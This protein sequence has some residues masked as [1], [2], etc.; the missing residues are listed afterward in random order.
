MT[1]RTFLR[2][3]MTKDFDALTEAELTSLHADVQDW[4]RQLA[5]LEQE[6]AARRAE[7]WWR[8]MPRED[9]RTI[10]LLLKGAR[11]TP[12]VLQG[13]PD[14]MHLL[15]LLDIEDPNVVRLWAEM[16]SDERA[17]R[18]EEVRLAMAHTDV[19]R[20]TSRW[21]DEKESVLLAY[22]VLGL[23]PAAAWS[24]VRR[25]YRE[26]SAKHHPDRGGDPQQFKT[27]QKA[28]KQLESRYL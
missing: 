14:L 24:D 28:Y 19:R 20:R 13:L 18:I 17:R 21:E 6:L 4:Q 25:A 5:E 2:E 9:M 27:L 15:L 3:L 11:L 7:R 16:T 22:D 23:T 10:R 1:D 12:Q 26:L 8:E